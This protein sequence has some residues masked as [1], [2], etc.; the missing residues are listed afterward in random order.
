M[1]S[2]KSVDMA[3][4]L[5]RAS[6]V[7]SHRLIL[8]PFLRH[9]DVRPVQQSASCLKRAHTQKLHGEATQPANILDEM[10]AMKLHSALFPATEIKSATLRYR[11][12]EPSHRQFLWG[13]S[14]M[15]HTNMETIRSLSSSS[16]SQRPP[17]TGD[18]A[19]EKASGEGEGSQPATQP[20]ASSSLNRAASAMEGKL[21]A[22]KLRF[23]PLHRERIA[24]WIPK[25]FLF[26]DACKNTFVLAC[27]HL[28]GCQCLSGCKKKNLKLGLFLFTKSENA[29]GTQQNTHTH[30]Y[31]NVHIH[32]SYILHLTVGMYICVSYIPTESV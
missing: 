22:S 17:D 12:L 21:R 31:P 25:C 10:G 2:F 18:K 6:L 28:R 20:N 8:K 29:G 27:E 15:T 13:T 26:R 16:S 3:A 1:L 24:P 4:K 5:P 11:R 32:I 30:Q 9:G 7:S 19:R 23:L 14:K